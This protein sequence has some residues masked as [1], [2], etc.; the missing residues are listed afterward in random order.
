MARLLIVDD[1]ATICWGLRRLAERL[2]HEALVCASAEEALAHDDDARFDA[3]MID[4]RLPGIDG[5]AAAPR[6]RERL[7]PVPIVVM[8]AYGDL[9]VAVDAVRGGAFEYLIK[10]FDLATAERV[11]RRAL[12]AQPPALPA[13][14]KIE[15]HGEMVGSIPAMQQVFKLVALAASSHA[16]VQI[17]GES[18]TGK[19]LVARA[20]HRFSSRAEAPFVAVNLASLSETVAESELFGHVRGAFTG[21]EHDRAGLIHQAR[22][23]TLFLDEVA[24]IPLSL[25]V[26]LLRALEQ[27]EVLPV[28]S[29]RPE[30]IDFRVVSATHR[31]LA[32][33]VA[34]GRFREDL[35][36]RLNTFSIPIPPLRERVADIALLAEHFLDTLS[37]KSTQPRPQITDEALAEL[38]QRRWPGNVRELRNV[39]EHALIVARGGWIG[40]DHL[41]ASTTSADQPSAVIDVSTAVR[42]WAREQY[43]AEAPQGVYE[44]LLEVV[45]R[46]LLEVA[47]ERHAGQQAAAARTLGLHRITVRKKMERLRQQRGPAE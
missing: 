8:T 7:G 11:M 1:D 32:S 19:E 18:G 3:V 25:Q 6:L 24:E 37:K 30:R 2:G 43:A 9:R 13:P 45:E 34:A 44:R 15:S 38:R 10:P 40:P 28:G 21:A 5:L 36:F 35:F 20:I 22:G 17:Q 29:S 27:G 46:P 39:I 12:E 33:C 41:P 42:N 14:E 47:F 23:G 26:K 16:C 4:V 31:D